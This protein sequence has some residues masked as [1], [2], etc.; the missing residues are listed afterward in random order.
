MTLGAVL[1]IAAMGL[2]YHNDQNLADRALA[3]KVDLPDPVLIQDFDRTTNSNLLG[4]LQVLVETNNDQS[5][6]R[7]FGEGEM[8]ESYLLLPVYPV[9]KGGFARSFRVINGYAQ[10][11]H[12]PVPRKSAFRTDAPIAVLVYDVTDKRLRPRDGD[13]FG[14]TL[15]G[16]GFNG[17][18]ALM[19]GVAFSRALWADG[20]TRSQVEVAARDVFAL[21]ES[22]TVPLIAPYIALRAAPFG[23]DMT[24]ARNFLGSVAIVALL[25]GLSLIKRSFAKRPAVVKPSGPRKPNQVGTRHSASFFDPLLPQDEIQKADKDQRVSSELSFAAISRRVGPRLSRL[26]SRR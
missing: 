11:P 13:A 2:T 15:L 22:E 21:P 3:T 6:L 16:R 8:R 19:S 26:R 18:V 5:V 24:E 14:L 20:T 17:D 4:E 23:S 7:Q 1:F 9:S 25:F 10:T 12:R